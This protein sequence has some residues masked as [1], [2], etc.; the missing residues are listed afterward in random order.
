MRGRDRAMTPPRQTGRA[1]R[2]ACGVVLIGTVALGVGFLRFAESLTTRETVPVRHADGLVVLTGGADRVSDAVELL[3]G[4]R[5][6]RLLITGV[7]PTTSPESLA[8]RLPKVRT[9]VECC[10]TLG[11][12][13]L[14]T[15]GNAQETA[16]WAA[17]N[18]IRSLIV[19]TS[20]YHMPR[21]LA[22]IAEAVDDV[23]LVPY[24]VVSETAKDC[25]WWRSLH[26]TRL[27]ASEYL[28]YVV[29]MMRHTLLPRPKPTGPAVVA[30]GG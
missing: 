3:V 23:E 2:V 12:R 13:A 22:E 21:A 28:K 1:W 4:G 10:V 20:N 5:A 19:V 14:D 7:N 17:A 24:P 8:R 18:H 11:Y 27:I 26:R 15:S 6:D 9:L 16:Q 25:A 29:V 30:Q